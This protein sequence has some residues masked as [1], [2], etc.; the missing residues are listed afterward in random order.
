MSAHRRGRTPAAHILL[1]IAVRTAA[2]DGCERAI[3]FLRAGKPGRAEYELVRT[4][5][6]IARLVDDTASLV[7]LEDLVYVEPFAAAGP[8]AS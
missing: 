2:E 5:V 7:E 6:R 4:G 1:T 3:R 8:V